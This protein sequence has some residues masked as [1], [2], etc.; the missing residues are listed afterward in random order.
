MFDFVNDAPFP[1]F[2][3]FT[4]EDYVDYMAVYTATNAPY[5]D[6]S[7][8]NLLV[9]LNIDGTLRISR[10]DDSLVLRYSNPFDDGEE[11]FILLEK[12]P[13][14][15]HFK[16]IFA[17]AR[18]EGVT[19][20]M[21]ELPYAT[22]PF[23]PASEFT[24]TPN[25]D[26]FEYILDTGLHTGLAGKSFSI[27]RRRMG[28]FK[29]VHEDDDID[30]MFYDH[31]GDEQKKLMLDLISQWKIVANEDN[32][33]SDNREFEALTYAIHTADILNRDLM[34]ICINGKPAAFS[35]FSIY[36]DTA[37]VGHIKVDYEIQYAFDFATYS[38]AC[39]LSGRGI[40]Y[41]NFEQDLGIPGLREHK[42]RL[43]PVRM[44]EKSDVTLA[45]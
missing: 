44:L 42:L 8:A 39:E 28:Y 17:L 21:R 13:G 20:S 25:R 40:P 30:V 5:A 38:L 27:Q 7:P 43:R 19:A 26:S 1:I 45:A 29:R 14:Y 24:V 12:A 37:I 11:N 3:N 33:S 34:L 15:E 9:W 31:I 41:M 35:L 32:L 2:R 6:I 23:L 18:D 36:G 4:A 22:L 16:K 10:L